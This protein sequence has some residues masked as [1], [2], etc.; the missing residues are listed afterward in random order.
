MD[1]VHRRGSPRRATLWRSVGGGIFRVR[2]PEGTIALTV[3]EPGADVLV[4]G[5]KVTVTW[6]AG[7]QH[8]EITIEPGN[9]SITVTKDG[10]QAVGKTI[11]IKDGTRSL[12]DVNLEPIPQSGQEQQKDPVVGTQGVSE[13]DAKE[14]QQLK[15][16][17]TTYAWYYSDDLYL[18]GG[19]LQFHPNGKFHDHWK[20][21]YWIVG[22]RTMHVQFWD[23]VYKPT[24]S[25][26]FQFNDDLTTFHSEFGT[27]NQTHHVTGTRLHLIGNA[28][29]NASTIARE[30]REQELPSANKNYPD[31]HVLTGDWIVEETELVHRAGTK[32]GH[33]L[34]GDRSWSAYNLSLAAKIV[35]GPQFHVI[36]NDFNHS[37]HRLFNLGGDNCDWCDLASFFRHHWDESKRRLKRQKFNR[38]EWYDIRL[39]VRGAECRCYIDGTCW[40]I[41]RDDRLVA[42]RIGFFAGDQ[43]TVRI[44]DLVVTAE[45]GNTVL[46]RG[47]PRLPSAELIAS[48]QVPAAKSAESSTSEQVTLDFT[49]ALN[50]VLVQV[51][52]IRGST[53]RY[54]RSESVSVALQ[55]IEDATKEMISKNAVNS[56]AV[57]KICDAVKNAVA[58]AEVVR[59]S[60]RPSRKK[61]ARESEN[62]IVFYLRK[63]ESIMRALE[64]GH[65]L[66]TVEGDDFET[67][68]NGHDL[69]GWTVESGDASQWTVEDGAIVARSQNFKTRNYLL[70][71]REIG[72]CNLDFEY[73]FDGAHSAGIAVRG[74]NGEKMPLNGN[75][76]VDHPLIKLGNKNVRDPLG[77]SH[78]LVDDRT[79]RAVP[80]QP[81]LE[82]KNWHHMSLHVIGD[83][84]EMSVN[85][86]PLLEAELV[87]SDNFSVEPGLARKRGKLGFQAHT[88]TVRFSK[89][90][91][92]NRRR[93]K[94]MI[95]V[96]HTM[97]SSSMAVTLSAHASHQCG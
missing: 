21:N 60:S 73:M 90:R 22:P 57:A 23:P 2:T 85:G 32:G 34:F 82:E 66:P 13:T 17:L 44:R 9:H 71:D 88:G 47:F 84:C 61:F 79:Y 25:V 39:E 19:Q 94:R 78:W 75:W 29:S 72:D 76:I 35:D 95:L 53:P 45:D 33:V 16:V 4:D 7:K 69:T 91:K 18:P 64:D 5:R 89:I 37:N 81:V 12:F 52:T 65:P 49:S 50:S 96:V 10:F 3:N 41:N 51:T 86:E 28:P 55:Q 67:I 46:W 58:A 1:L 31:P 15:E 11:A 27:N 80:K 24:T 54:A 26:V 20:W 48:S 14:I 40:L 92:I 87:S 43:A 63:I 59:K 74:R 36:F 97:V 56:L 6:D 68:F 62:R 77:A 93:Q 38:N 30:S 8:S 70:F 83:A 42:G